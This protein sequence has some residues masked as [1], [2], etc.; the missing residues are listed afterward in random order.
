[1]SIK[2][3]YRVAVKGGGECDVSPGVAIF[4]INEE[5]AR[6]IVKL[7]AMVRANDLH[8]VEKFDYR[9]EFLQFDPETDPE[10][11]A[12]AGEENF[13]RTELEC[14]NVTRDDFFISA[15]IKHTGIKVSCVG[16]TIADLMSHFGLSDDDSP[17]VGNVL[18]QPEVQK[19]T[20][21]S[22][23]GAATDPKVALPTVVVEMDCGAILCVRSSVPARVILLDAD[24]ESADEDRIQEVNGEEVYVHHYCLTEQSN[25]GNDGID[26]TFVTDVLDQVET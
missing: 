1:M 21:V 16:Q 10:D 24:T 26:S 18:V 25:D 23:R 8:K 12:E 6:Q 20:L 2:K 15:Y 13:V 17:G 9:A 14:L 4:D 7:A 5:E 19:Q 3:T 11:A 22:N